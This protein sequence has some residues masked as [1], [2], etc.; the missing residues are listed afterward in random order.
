MPDE[1]RFTVTCRASIPL[2]RNMLEMELVVVGQDPNDKYKIM[3]DQQPTFPLMANDSDDD[4]VSREEAL[5]EETSE[6]AS[7]KGSAEDAE[8]VDD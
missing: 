1:K 3:S 5:A 6:D 2:K 4:E 8:V 7:P